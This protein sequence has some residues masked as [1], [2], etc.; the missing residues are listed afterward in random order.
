MTWYDDR[1]LAE[2]ETF[3]AATKVSERVTKLYRYSEGVFGLQA[4]LRTTLTTVLPLEG[5]ILLHAAAMADGDRAMVFFG[6]SGAGKSTLAAAATCEVLTDELVALTP[7]AGGFAARAT[8]FWGTLEGKIPPRR[9]VRLCA[10]VQLGKGP[11]L[12]VSPLGPTEAF[13]ALI[14][15]AMFYPVHG[16]APRAIAIL[17]RLVSASPAFQMKWAPNTNAWDEI[18]NHILGPS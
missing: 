9:A 11:A 16:V 13:H 3:V 15:T 17:G 2:H 8:G 18:Q 1:I 4:A 6:E 5:G 10:L 14:R 12:E 7:T